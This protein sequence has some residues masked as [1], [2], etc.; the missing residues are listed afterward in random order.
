MLPKA[1]YKVERK[2]NGEWAK[3]KWWYEAAV[4]V[5]KC[6]EKRS[7]YYIIGVR[8]HYRFPFYNFT[9]RTKK[10]NRFKRRC[11]FFRKKRHR[12]CRSSDAKWN[13]EFLLVYLPNSMPNAALHTHMYAVFSHFFHPL[14]FLSLK[15]WI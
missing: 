4:S 12:P 15:N 14:L 5:C 9:K 11:V 7:R 13:K 10:I 2:K 3:G 8:F 6:E 1:K